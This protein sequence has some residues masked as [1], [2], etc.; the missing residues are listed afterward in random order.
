MR[1]LFVAATV[2]IGLSACATTKLPPPA[3]E[4]RTVRVE[5]PVAQPCLAAEQIPPVPPRIA[6]QLTGDARHDLD[7]VSA[8]ALRLR[9]WGEQMHAA[10][11]AC[12]AK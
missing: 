1:K 2:I 6:D 11:V 3:V 9:S 7:L 12:A 4:L 5:I 10:L 8:S